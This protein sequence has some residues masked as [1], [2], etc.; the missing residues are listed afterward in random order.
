[1][2]EI[3]EK[4][5]VGNKDESVLF[6]CHEMKVKAIRRTGQCVCVRKNKNTGEVVRSTQCIFATSFSTLA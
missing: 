5:Q 6:Q 1:M 3:V 2:T 4:E